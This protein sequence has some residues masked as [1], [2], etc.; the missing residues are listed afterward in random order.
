MKEGAAEEISFTLP[1]D[2]YLETRSGRISPKQIII[3]SIEGRF[4]ITDGTDE[5]KG[6]KIEVFSHIPGSSVVYSGRDE[7]RRYPLPL[8]I[9]STGRELKIIATENIMRYSI[10]SAAAELGL[11]D[12]SASEALYALAHAILARALAATEGSKHAGAHFCDLTC[13]QT[14]RGRTG[15]DFE[16]T[17]TIRPEYGRK[18]FFG[19]SGGG[20]ILTGAV[21]GTDSNIND[22]PMPD[23]I[24]SEN[25]TLSRNLYPSWSA[26]ISAG[27]MNAILYT[28]IKKRATEIIYSPQCQVMTL[29]TCEGPFRIAPETFRLI[30]NRVKGWSFIKSNNYTVYSHNGIFIFQGSGLGHCAGLSIEGAVQLARR[31]YSRYEILEHYYPWIKYNVRK[32]SPA[33]HYHAFITFDLRSGRIDRSSTSSPFLSR[34]LPFGS[35]SKLVTVLYLAAE[36]RD[37]FYNYRFRCAKNHSDRNLPET[38]WEE[39]GHGDMDL[40][41]AIYSSCNLYFASLYSEINRKKYTQWVKTFALETGIDIDLPLVKNDREFAALLAGLDFRLNVSVSGL[42]KLALLLSPGECEDRRINSFRG[43]IRTDEFREI[44]DALRCTMTKG[45]GSHGA[46]G[47]R[48]G[49]GIPEYLRP[50]TWGKTGTVISGTNS[51]CGYGIFIGGCGNTGIVSVL[52]KGTGSIA[53]CYSS[54]ILSAEYKTN[55]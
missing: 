36:R 9:T 19:S 12:D 21:F 31:G 48:E 39:H 33:Y 52:R 24:F 41:S 50:A 37:L 45:T 32:E 40:R 29:N 17:V 27:E 44:H 54:C 7:E 14:Y 3:R 1:R 4:I 15:F 22:Q 23:V 20:I 25:L 11:Y 47:C 51:H 16:D 30:I 49:T 43:K 5:I 46:D 13:C 26:E 6:P 53:A 18:I 28:A 38:C 10:D 35:V 42:I 2:S 8:E 34:R 55:L